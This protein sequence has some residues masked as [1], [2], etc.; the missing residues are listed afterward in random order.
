LKRI[1]GGTYGALKEMSIWK[2]YGKGLMEHPGNIQGTHKGTGHKEFVCHIRNQHKEQYLSNVK[3]NIWT[4]YAK[5]LM[6]H[7]SIAY[8]TVKE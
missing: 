3:C 2:T 5:R 4:R 1:W 7:V 8:G 6:E